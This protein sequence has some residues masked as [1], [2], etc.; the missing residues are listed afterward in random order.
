MM[1]VCASLVKVMDAV[2]EFFV[3][4]DR[5]LSS[6]PLLIEQ[7]FKRFE[8]TSVEESFI[9]AVHANPLMLLGDGC[10]IVLQELNRRITMN[11]APREKAL[12]N[13]DG[14]L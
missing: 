11:T 8:F 7:L 12:V 1:W 13:H 2:E 10:L 5:P 14:S 3:E 9:A 6:Q 4:R